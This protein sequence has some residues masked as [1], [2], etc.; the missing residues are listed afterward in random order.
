MCLP[1][2]LGFTL[3]AVVPSEERGVLRGRR[4]VSL[5]GRLCPLSATRTQRGLLSSLSRLSPP[6]T[7]IFSR[8]NLYPYQP[9]ISCNCVLKTPKAPKYAADLNFNPSEAGL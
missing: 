4:L 2:P 1:G 8:N 9:R 3:P 7:R 6:P 5:S